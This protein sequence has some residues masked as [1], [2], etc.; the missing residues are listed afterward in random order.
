MGEQK[1]ILNFNK[2][3]AVASLHIICTMPQ[4][5]M[6]LD[7]IRGEIKFYT[8]NKEKNVKRLMKEK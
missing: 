4:A 2:L 5:A 1:I 6:R 7:A 3:Q 8:V